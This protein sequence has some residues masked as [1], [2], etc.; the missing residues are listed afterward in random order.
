MTEP[1]FTFKIHAGMGV[2]R[3]RNL[4]HQKGYIRSSGQRE[5]E[6]EKVRERDTQR[7]R[8]TEVKNV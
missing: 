5:K 4:Y 6:R 1:C 8:L 2:V 7:E 3:T